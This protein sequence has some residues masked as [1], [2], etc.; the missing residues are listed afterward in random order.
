MKAITTEGMG[1]KDHIDNLRNLVN[2]ALSDLVPEREPAE[3]FEPVGYALEGQGKRLRPILVLLSGEI[4]GVRPEDILPGALAVEVFHTFTLVHD[5]IMDRSAE[6]RGRPTVHTKWDEGTAILCGDYLMALSYELLSRLP[7]A[8]LNVLFRRYHTMVTR[9][10]EGQALDKAFETRE[11]VSVEE[12]LNMIDA[13]TGALL[14]LSLELGAYAGGAPQ[15]QRHTL[16]EIGRYLG[17]AFQIQ[18]DLLDIAAEDK[19][20]GK[21]IGGD[22]VAGKKTYILLRAIE[23]ATAGDRSW[24]SRI[25]KGEMEFG[26]VEETRRRI[27]QL[28]ILDEARNAV[29]EHTHFARERLNRLPQGPA[30]GALNY[31]IDRLSERIH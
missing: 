13:K 30:V 24:L 20:W 10:C 21:P 31:L 17:R 28:G 26:E 7:I 14:E 27:E 1:Y 23:R 16:Q 3:L 29:K 6:R 22:L 19:R 12:Y 2:K 11:D 15:E 4:F 5:D 18:D 9:L 8:E 25:V